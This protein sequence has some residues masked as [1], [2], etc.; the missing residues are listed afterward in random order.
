MRHDVTHDLSVTARKDERHACV[1]E[2]DIH[3]DLRNLCRKDCGIVTRHKYEEVNI[4]VWRNRQTRQLEGLVL[5][6]GS[7]SSNL[8][9]PTM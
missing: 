7:R 3:V 9:M 8:L 4:G 1:V 2:L 6:N 5:S